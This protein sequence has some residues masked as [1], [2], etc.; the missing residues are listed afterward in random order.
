MKLLHFGCLPRLLD[1]IPVAII[2]GIVRFDSDLFFVEANMKHDRNHFF[3][4]WSEAKRF[5]CLECVLF[6]DRV[7]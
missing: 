2:A 6:S 4:F 5:L 7:V 1:F 3:P